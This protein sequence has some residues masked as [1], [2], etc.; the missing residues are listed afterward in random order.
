M[1]EDFDLKDVFNI[2]ETG[3]LF[4]TLPNKLLNEIGTKWFGEKF[5]GSTNDCITMFSKQWK[6][7]TYVD[8]YV[9]SD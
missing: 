2:N 5:K 6:S 9:Q 3:Y 4:F 7:A 8:W 1:L